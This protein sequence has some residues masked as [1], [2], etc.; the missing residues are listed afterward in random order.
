MLAECPHTCD[1][2]VYLSLVAKCS[3]LFH[4]LCLPATVYMLKSAGS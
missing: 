1:Y 3:L 4:K 2:M